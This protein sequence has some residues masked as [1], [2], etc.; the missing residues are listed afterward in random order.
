MDPLRIY[1]YLTVSRRRLF[2][3]VRPL[4]AEQYRGEHPIGLG[5]LART[6]HHCRAAEAMYMRRVAG[7]A[8]V[9]SGLA[10][11][12]DPEIASADAL[13]FPDLERIWMETVETTRAGL[14][15]ARGGG[16]DTPRHIVSS[17]EGHS[18]EYDASPADFFCQLVV[19]E[20]HHRAQAAHMLR[21]LGVT[22]G[23]I[24]YSTLMFL[25]DLPG[26]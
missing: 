18:F 9:P 14:E 22:V 21:R 5:S 7:D 10:P 12:D 20:V 15:R 6:L 16:W 26:G 8:G 25:P 1:E 17:W 3:G 13:P 23:E 4:S 19:H 2:D 24:D 11:A